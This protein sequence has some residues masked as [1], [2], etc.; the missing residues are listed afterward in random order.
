MQNSLE[1]DNGQLVWQPT[2]VIYKGKR[3]DAPVFLT[4]LQSWDLISS[5]LRTGE[6]NK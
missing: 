1:L 6:W 4:T 2:S 5:L 3:F